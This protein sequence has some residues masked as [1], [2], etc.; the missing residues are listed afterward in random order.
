MKTFAIHIS[1]QMFYTTAQTLE[2]AEEIAMY[3]YANLHDKIK[4]MKE[5][6]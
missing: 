4:E 2:D 1:E 6:D 3:E 5:N